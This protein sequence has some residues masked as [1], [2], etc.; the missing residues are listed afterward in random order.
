MSETTRHAL[1]D[2]VL[3]ALSRF[4]F[5]MQDIWISAA[6]FHFHNLD[7]EISRLPPGAR[8]L[9]I[10]CGAGILMTMLQRANPVIRIEGIEPLEEGFDGLADLR[11]HFR[12]QGARIGEMGYERFSPERRYD[13]VYLVNV[14]EHLKD[15]RH[16]L[17]ILPRFLAPGGRCLILCPNYGFPFEPHFNRPVIG[18]KAF[19][20]RLYQARI[21]RI[22]RT[23]GMHGLWD[24]LNFVRL[25][26]VKRH[27]AGLPLTLTVRP[28][29]S[30][31]MLARVATDA[32]F[33]E[34]LALAGHLA[35]AFRALGAARLFRLAILENCQP[36]MF[37]D[38]R[39]APPEEGGEAGDLRNVRVQGH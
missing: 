8:V 26:E 4:D 19:M 2:Q 27:V 33:Q 28:E 3:D 22:E 31:R 18:S 11:R 34:H 29:I 1:A 12:D 20:R 32:V 21:D 15:W 37:L 14:L 9:E 5:P 38:L 25:S 16:F 7:P 30:D 17:D 13:L 36:Y 35:R 24:S 10:G 39:C 6:R 23:F